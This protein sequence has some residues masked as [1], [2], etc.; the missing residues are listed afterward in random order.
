LISPIND[1]RNNPERSFKRLVMEMPSDMDPY[2]PSDDEEEEE[3]E[4]KEE[5]VGR[6]EGKGDEVQKPQPEEQP[7]ITDAGMPKVRVFRVVY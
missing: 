7:G 2:E 1:V 4:E 6:V 3:E 5:A